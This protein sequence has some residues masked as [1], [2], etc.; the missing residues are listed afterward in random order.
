MRTDLA[1]DPAVIGI[2]AALD[3]HEDLVV[4]K[5]HRFWSWADAQLRDGNAPSVTEKWIDRYVDLPGFAHAM[6]NAGWLTVAEGGISIPNFDRHNGKAAKN[7][8]LTAN[9]VRN[10]RSVTNARIGNASSVTDSGNGSFLPICISSSKKKKEETH[11]RA[12]FAPPTVS[13]V[14][15]FITENSLTVDPAEFV[16]HYTANGWKIGGKTAMKDWRASVRTWHRRA[17]KEGKGHGPTSGNGH[18]G[19]IPADPADYKNSRR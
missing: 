17:L 15:D 10:A 7:R 1:D 14:A 11:K 8:A 19:P 9:R 6:Q 18:A 13:E 3:I 12:T 5:L 4:G 2:A 16:D